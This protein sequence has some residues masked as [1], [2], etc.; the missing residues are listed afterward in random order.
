MILDHSIGLQKD[1]LGIFHV[2]VNKKQS[3]E[4]II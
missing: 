2:F 4:K 3:K 1:L